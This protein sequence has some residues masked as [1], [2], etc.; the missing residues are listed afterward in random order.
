MPDPLNLIMI[1]EKSCLSLNRYVVIVAY[2]EAFI[3]L[4]TFP[5]WYEERD[6]NGSDVEVK[7]FPSR[8]VSQCVLLALM[9]GFSL[10]VISI[11]WQHINSSSMAETLNYG[12]VSGH[13]GVGSMALGWAAAAI[14]GIVGSAMQVVIS[15]ISLIRRLTD[16]E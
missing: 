4:S 6:E 5:G 8:P 7:P 12:A 9:L 16:E 1:A 13:I 10:G 14:I 11:L 2:V 15:S 3:L